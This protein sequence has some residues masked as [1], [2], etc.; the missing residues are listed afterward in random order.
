MK[1]TS[2]VGVVLAVAYLVFPPTVRA[3][4]NSWISPTRGF[5]DDYTKWLLNVAP[6][7]SQSAYITNGVSKTV[8]IDSI[9]SGTYPDTMTVSNLYLSAPDGLTNTLD[10]SDAGLSSPLHILDT[11]SIS[12]GGLLYLTNSALSM[13][14][15]ATNS[16][17]NG[18]MSVDGSVVVDANGLLTLDSGLYVGVDA[19]ATGV[20]LLTGGQI[21]LTNAGPSAIGVNGVGQ[22]IVSNGTVQSSGFIFVGSGSGSHGT[23]TVAG[24]GSY[25][26][27]LNG[28]LIVG[29]ETGSVGVVSIT[30][31]LVLT[32]SFITIVGGG[33]SGQL[34]LSGGT[35]MLGPM[36]IGADSGSQGTLTITGGTNTFQNVVLIGAGLGAT[37][38]VWIT[39][40]Q[41][42]Q[43]NTYL[44]SSSVTNWWP[45]DVGERG[46]GQLTASNVNWRGGAMIVGCQSNSQGAVNLVGG[47]M[48]LSSSLSIGSRSNSLGAVGLTGGSLT[49]TN[50][51]MFV[52]DAGVG[53]LSLSNS[54]VQARNVLVGNAP[55]SQGVLFLDSNSLLIAGGSLSIGDGGIGQMTV[56]G[57]SVRATD[58]S[59]ANASGSSGGIVLDTNSI[60]I[61]D[62]GLYIGGGTNAN[63][64]CLLK[65]GQLFATNALSGIGIGVSG[66]GQAI[67]SNSE[68]RTSGSTVV[69]SSSGSQG[70]LTVVGGDYVSLPF[71]RLLIGMETGAVGTVSLTDVN[72]VMT[73]SFIT[74][75]GGGGSGQLNLS[76]GTATFGPME[77]GGNPG[78]QGTLT[79]AGGVN[80][81]QGALFVGTSIGATGTVWMTSGQLIA[82]NLTT[83]VGSWGDGLV[84]VSNGNWLGGSMML[85]IYSNGLG[86]VNVDGGSV[87]LLTKLALGNCPTGGMGVVNVAGGSLYVTNATHNAFIDVRNGQLNLNG[88]LLQMD[89]LVMTNACGLFVRGGGTLIVGSVVLDPN[90]SAIGDG[91]PNGWK[92]QYGLNPLDPT[93]AN[94]DPDGDGLSNLQEF[95]A[96]TDPTNS[97]SYLRITSMQAEGNDIRIT[98]SAVTSKTYAVELAT[99]TV[100]GSFTNAFSDLV[101]VTVPAATA[102]TET[103]YL[104]AG[105]VTNGVTRFYRVRVIAP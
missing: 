22:M 5:W 56:L 71:T 40:G 92:Q 48:A 8:T 77:V 20:V 21:F 35:N 89:I 25:V 82:T 99:N 78:S 26:P 83:C 59:V 39:G 37:G 88:G 105:A 30:S 3:Q 81:L 54:S 79:V 36:E 86:T 29:M 63:G 42:V 101:T 9:T 12:G 15:V 84:T 16:I 93:V 27:S 60:L 58:V 85:G 6:S 46:F 70:A 7:N 80:T 57:G 38:A 75:V 10:L 28:R 44:G 103:N 33:G 31:G 96:G 55:G 90:L 45:T 87:T 32:N 91:I 72:L 73:N 62:G 66:V 104:D 23:L 95:L 4:T 50:A 76:D 68:V 34:N 61:T 102:I 2:Y 13:S 14:V 65:S 69:G 19:G 11:F 94:A 100:D 74:I 41:L 52:G 17:T 97:A 51:S 1:A 98:W 43:T 47:S 18:V 67:I 24:G 53:Q 64:Y 49:V